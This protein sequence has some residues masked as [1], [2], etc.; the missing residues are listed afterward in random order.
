[1]NK[2]GNGCNKLIA[3]LNNK[4]LGQSRVICNVLKLPHGCDRLKGA[5]M[6]KNR[7]Q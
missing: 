3:R 1:M 7:L 5:P 2:Y 4:E 6:I